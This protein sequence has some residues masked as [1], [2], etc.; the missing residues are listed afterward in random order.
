MSEEVI[1]QFMAQDDISPVIQTLQSNVVTSM[2]QMQ[3]AIQNMSSGFDN[4]TVSVNN[5]G[6]AQ[7]VVIGS[8]KDATNV[9]KENTK[10]NNDN[11][12]SSKNNST[13]QK[14]VANSSRNASQGLKETN[15]SLKINTD[16][17][18]LS[19]GSSMYLAGQLSSLGTQAEAA[20]RN[21]NETKI[22][23]DQVAK[24]AGVSDDQ[25]ANY[26]TTMSNETFPNEEAILYSKNLTQM[27]VDAK[28]F[29]EQGTNID[30]IN[31]AFG[32]GAE[33]T[34]SLVTELSVLGVDMNN[35]SESFNALAYAN[36]NTKGG[37]ENFYSFLRKYDSQLNELGYNTDQAAIIISAATH[38]FGGGRAALTGLSKALDE[39]GSDSNALES[40][41]GLQTNSLA[42]A[43]EETSS[44]E[45]QLQ[46]LADEEMEHK[47]ILDR[48][49][50]AWDDFKLQ[51]ADAITSLQAGMGVFGQVGHYALMGNA[52][53]ELIVGMRSLSAVKGVER[54]IKNY[55]ELKT[56][57]E[58]ISKQQALG[59]VVNPE[60]MTPV[61]PKQGL[62]SSIK[63]K[64][65][66][67]LGAGASAG[68]SAGVGKNVGKTAS[69]TTQ[70][71][72][73]AGAVGALA[74]EAEAA[75]AGTAATGG[76]MSGIATAFTTLIV[77]LL[78]I[79]AVIAVMLPIIA[80]LAAEAL[81][82]IKGIQLLIDSLDFDSIDL[83]SSIEAIK[84]IGEAIWEVARAMGAMA[85]ANVLT[86]VAVFTGGISG[87]ISPLGVATEYLKRA[88]EELKKFGDVEIPSSVA[89]NI[90]KIG[91][92]IKAVTKAF[93]A[94]IGLNLN[95]I[96]GNI[97]TLGG[98]LGNV[99]DAISTAREEIIY[100]GQEI[101]KI[102]NVPNIDKSVA[103]K[104]EKIGSSLESIG[105]A[106]ES[107][108]K[109]RDQ[110]N[111]DTGWFNGWFQN[112]DIQESLVGIKDTIFEAAKTLSI[113]K[114]MPAVD[115]KV[116]DKLSKVG[117]A[118]ESIGKAVESLKTIKDQYNWD[119][120]MLGGLFQDFDV[121]GA[122]RGVKGDIWAV[123]GELRTMNDMP[124]I[125]D[126]ASKKLKKT[127]ST[128]KSVLNT[129]KSMKDIQKL[130][131]GG[132]NSNFDGV[133][134]TIKNARTAI[135]QVSAH[136]RALSGISAIKEGTEN[137]IKQVTKVIKDVVSAISEMN[138][139]NGVSL[140]PTNLVK[141]FRD[142]RVTIG[143]IS[144]GLASY[145]NI[146]N[147]PAGVAEKVKNVKDTAK[148]VVD[149]IS[150]LNS[151]DGQSLN[152]TN[153][154][155]TF[156]DARV[157][158]GTISTGLASYRNIAN[159]PENVAPKVQAVSRT[160]NKVANAIKTLNNVDKI[161]FNGANLT[162][163]FQNARRSIGTVS[164]S[165]ASYRNI[166][167]VPDNVA[168]KLNKVGSTSRR[169][170]T[171][172][173][174]IKTVPDVNP[175]AENIKN[176]VKRTKKTIKELNK[177]KGSKVGN[178]G[179]VLK[180]VSSAVT[181]LKKSLNSSKGSFKGTGKAIGNSLE[182]GIKSGLASLH[183]TVT[184]T[185][186]TAFRSGASSAWTGGAVMAASAI[187]GFKSAFLLG[188]IISAE[189]SAG[190]TAITSATPDLT[191]AMGVLADNMVTE[192]K[193]H[194]EIASPG[195]VA[196]AI[197][198]EMIY[199]KNF[200]DTRGQ[201]VI[202]SVGNL[203]RNMVNTFN[204]NLT[205]P[206]D[207]LNLNDARLNAIRGLNRNTNTG[208]GS[209]QQPVTIIISEGAIKLDVANMSTKESRQIL[210][211]ALE[212][213]DV[214]ESVNIKGV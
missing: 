111:W 36:E 207:S 124:A 167:N 169:V 174:G 50:A 1:L 19:A 185:V 177:L 70:V 18:T 13:G 191:N 71:V 92:S 15:E 45:G 81:L 32:L 94:L 180:K 29:V 187:G 99:K 151:L 98:L 88:G 134:N 44:Y 186:S 28:N 63:S 20:A 183:T 106:Y 163:T 108:G 91:D 90:K 136:M 93:D 11:A 61:N 144:T 123:A 97:L 168:G 25:M 126:T 128:L 201:G 105:K 195:A 209:N 112:F 5:I 194:A 104:L 133:V 85:L 51:H 2:E 75:A 56:V 54:A 62:F 117:S 17:N 79:A 179:G 60:A 143:T 142:A 74:P 37:M 141:T 55:K 22:S 137:K 103:G 155:K 34:N 131:S 197:R 190:L 161:D 135:Y 129:I 59:R 176:A 170:A 148:Q 160:A 66:G 95:M 203:A 127:A 210:V 199:G 171:A 80:G 10:A 205:N 165:L 73:N 175:D 139:I 33:T 208:Q 107:L 118:L 154:A 181:Q 202:S 53:K 84:Q 101:A 68:A 46:S 138:K 39:A 119:N 102:K 166:A 78:A 65:T 87:L 122:L 58:V 16:Y 82:L 41:L 4:A 156:R 43:S 38:K 178:V 212:G 121:I 12:N 158:I 23:L 14:E 57:Q 64:F 192:F 214:V 24:M 69:E 83:T 164:V 147:I 120:G 27:G 7:N 26:V 114:D 3:S 184:T 198:D 130:G 76:A 30:K 21:L 40:A 204:P 189:M 196:R 86:I 89:S 200:V 96:K 35:I 31:D 157:A 173:N 9:I 113:Y 125:S 72:K 213:L 100:A 116:G 6:K 77:P 115:D 48:V 132:S 140:N 42:H 206:L 193:S 149:I 110:Y 47:T 188:Q 182:S 146:A 67:G 49:G 153:L 152:P 150:T 52:L 159:I 8:G 172:I 162:T 109:I 211:N 145:K